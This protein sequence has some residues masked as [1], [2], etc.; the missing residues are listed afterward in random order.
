MGERKNLDVINRNILQVLYLYE[1]LDVLR[2]WYELGKRARASQ[3]PRV[4]GTNHGGG[5][6]YTLGL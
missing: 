1:N 4:C 2:L 6:E 3:G 5:R